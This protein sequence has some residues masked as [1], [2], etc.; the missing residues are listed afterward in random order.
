MKTL[1]QSQIKIR[2]E[3]EKSFLFFNFSFLIGAFCTLLFSI[4]NTAFAYKNNYSSTGSKVSPTPSPLAGCSPG[5]AM[6]DL[7][8]NNVRARMCTGGDMWWDYAK[9][10]GQYEVPKGSGIM[11]IYAGALWIGGMNSGNL[12][13]AGQE[14]RSGGGN[15][16]WPG[17]LDTTGGANITSA[18]CQQYDQHYKITQKEV[19]DFVGGIGP[20][21]T[22]ISNWPGNGNT[23]IG[24]AKYLAP[25]FDKNGDGIYRPSDGDYPGFD[26]VNGD[27]ACAVNNCIPADHLFGDQCLWWVMN[28]KGNIHTNTNGTPMGLEVHCQAF[29][30]NTDDEINSMTFVNYRIYNRSTLELDS[31]Y[32]G[33]WCDPDLGGATDDH[34]GCDVSRGLGYVYNETNN[35]GA[36][37]SELGYGV[38]PPAC[39]IDFF[40]GPIT[41]P[42]GV[43]GDGKDNNHNGVID[44]PCEQAIMT[45]FTYFSNLGAAD[46]H[47]DPALAKEYYNYL[48][49]SWKD[50]S[51]VVYGGLG[52]AGSA[53][54][55]T[56]PSAYVYP[57]NPA[58]SQNSDPIGWGIGG[59]ILGGVPHPVA[60]P[61]ANWWDPLPGNPTQD[62][63]RFVESAGP[64]RLMPG[65]VNVVTVGVVFA[66][67][68]G[69]NLA[70]INLMLAADDKAQ[71]LFDNCFQVLNGPD[72]PDLTIQELDK[73]LIVYLTNKPSSNNYNENYREYDPSI[74][75][76]DNHGAALHCI[77]TAYHFEGY[78]IF[79]LKDGTVSAGDLYNSDGSVNTAKAHQIAQCDV[80]NGVSTIVNY[81]FY[82]S[83][84]ASVPMT[85]VQ[86]SDAGIFHSLVVTKDD[87]NGTPIVNHKTYYFM[88][89]AYG[90]NNFKTYKQDGLIDTANNKCPFPATYTPAMDG[91]KKPYK[92]G[93]RNILSY[94]AIPHATTPYI[95]GTQMNSAYGS[96]PMIT[97]VEGNGNGG[98]ILDFTPATTSAILAS[99]SGKAESLTY[100]AGKGPVNITVVDPLNVPD[101]ASFTL[102]Y[103]DLISIRYN[104]LVG[105]F[106]VGETIKDSLSPTDIATAVVTDNNGS[107][108]HIKT[109][110]NGLNNRSFV[111]GD[112][113]I[114]ATSRATSSIVLYG[115]GGMDNA[116]W[117][118]KNNATSEVIYSDRTIKLINEQL[119]LQYGLAI[120]IVQPTDPGSQK[121]PNGFLEAT[122]SPASSWLTGVKDA[123]GVSYENW[124]RSGTSTATPYQDYVNSDNDKV[125]QGLIGGTWA[126]HG[127]CAGSRVPFDITSYYSGPGFNTNYANLSKLSDLASVDVVI[128]SDKSKWTR[129]DVL[130]MCEITT[131]AQGGARKH[132]KRVAPSVDKYGNPDGT[133]NTW[134][135]AGVPSTGMGWFPG[136]AINLETGERLNMAF[137]ENSALTGGIYEQNGR[138]M[139][140]NPTST[141]TG[142]IPYPGKVQ[143]DTIGPVFGGQ[144]YIY[145]FGHNSKHLSPSDNDNVPCY[146]GAKFMDSVLS[147]SGGQPATPDKRGIFRDAMW[148][149]LPLLTAGHNLLESD[150]TIRL[151]VGKTYKK[152][153]AT[154]TDTAATAQNHNAP[155]YTFGTSGIATQNFQ[156]SVAVDALDLINVVPNP[157]YAY[158]A[159]ENNALD[160]RI[161]I[162]NLPEQCT[163]S[164]YNLGGTLIRRIVKGEAINNQGLAPKGYSSPKEWSDGSVDWDL[165]NTAGT[166]I[167]S[168]V[169]IIHVEIPGVGERVVKWFG[170]MRPID[171]GSF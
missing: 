36:N 164:I 46:P 40:R 156:N 7:D 141:I 33:Q 167:A 3:K 110:T 126:P 149:S 163:I 82:P 140:W 85:E 64:I 161:K 160:N 97:R 123:D 24:Q 68:T 23:S 16:W 37:G 78:R 94:S 147:L 101:G 90:Y 11:P 98:M 26:M 12:Y 118:L 80:K 134:G 71:K 41:N 83:L 22:A 92:Q 5:A 2:K 27:N 35:D 117:S 14:Y 47:S 57:W 53:G 73:K 25:F 65:A 155:M 124:I 81:V 28:D 30:F 51:P 107:I 62:D 61:V 72:A 84:N 152:G 89:T 86:G 74:S 76:T 131:L 132:D 139:K 93:R 99:A 121:A 20:A 120:S 13:L 103:D 34:V 32:V 162:T 150:V 148:V 45:H 130:E 106:Q 59:Y 119:I 115:P 42:T 154:I 96:G 44:E 87:F 18:T 112:K 52:Y 166:P 143:T 31:T 129:C 39:G 108:M 29:A 159:Y 127:L 142:P 145:I 79:Q 15:D 138:D 151:R 58:N 1:P 67:S 4:C 70:S 43:P 157:Y 111:Y 113:I 66:R 128:T 21:T 69:G 144:H 133:F 38:S 135:P 102:K 49:G 165:K 100:L 48:S 88:A 63:R 6:T 55:S 109:I 10:I 169:Y 136:Y 122:V 77:D 137:G 50:G 146:D 171:L 56:I 116:T 8:V 168:G 125:Y 104:T 54:A 158:S 170:V 9:Q 17:P 91:Q 95:G 153:Y 75:L 114:G 19:S 60:A 105:T